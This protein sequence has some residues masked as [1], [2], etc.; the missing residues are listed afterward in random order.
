MQNESKITCHFIAWRYN[1]I[2]YCKLRIAALTQN[3]TFNFEEVNPV[4]KVWCT[5]AQNKRLFNDKPGLDI[6]WLDWKSF[7]NS[8]HMP[9]CIKPDRVWSTFKL[10]FSLTFRCCQCFCQHLF[11]KPV[12]PLH[13]H[14]QRCQ[15]SLHSDRLSGCQLKTR[16]ME[17]TWN[18]CFLLKTALILCLTARL[19]VL[20][21]IWDYII[22]SGDN[23]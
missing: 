19:N 9:V 5:M 8:S 22:I 14:L 13:L 16:L 15:I 3:I 1:G 23:K 21:M 10:T 4:R 17:E 20:N 11:A 7:M 6:F 18:R 2:L 12:I